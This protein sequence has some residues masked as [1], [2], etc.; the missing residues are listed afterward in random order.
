MELAGDRV[1][2]WRTCDA[3]K[4][5]RKGDHQHDEQREVREAYAPTFRRVGG[6]CLSPRLASQ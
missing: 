1:V 6:R 3:V 4:P 5:D 2:E